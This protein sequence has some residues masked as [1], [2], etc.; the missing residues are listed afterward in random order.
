M[1]SSTVPAV[2]TVQRRKFPVKTN[3]T[4][5]F[6]TLKKHIPEIMKLVSENDVTVVSAATGSG[7]STLIPGALALMY[8]KKRVYVAVPTITAAI[9]LCKFASELY[10]NVEFGYGANGISK[11]RDTTQ[12]IYCTTGRIKQNILHNRFD[13]I[14][15]YLMIDEAHGVDVT[16]STLLHLCQNALRNREQW[17]CPNLKL[18]ISSATIDIDSWNDIFDSI[19]KFELADRS[20]P[21]DI[22]YNIR[23]YRIDEKKELTQDT[24]SLV[25]DIHC[26]GIL[27]KTFDKSAILVF[28]DS[29]ES[30][31]EIIETLYRHPKMQDCAILPAYSKLSRDELDE[32][33]K[34]IQVLNKEYEKDGYQVR[35]KIVVATNIAE[36]AITIPDVCIVVDMMR[37]RILR[38]GINNNNCLETAFTSQSESNQRSGRAGR[39]APGICFR[40]CNEM[41]FIA[42][43]RHS[44]PE[45]MRIVL[46]DQVL[47]LLAFDYDAQNILEMSESKY[48]ITLESLLERNL[49]TCSELGSKYVVTELGNFVTK[50]PTGIDMGIMLN[51]FKHNPLQ[52]YIAMIIVS[53]IDAGSNGN[54]F[55][56][57]RRNRNQTQEEHNQFLREYKEQ[58]SRFKGECDL[59]QVIKIFYAM[60]HE[61]HLVMKGRKQYQDMLKNRLQQTDTI[62]QY[63]MSEIPK[64]RTSYKSYVDWSYDNS[65]NN[66]VRKKVVSGFYNLEK[67]AKSLKIDYAIGT[68]EESL[69]M[70]PKIRKGIA[71]AL[72]FAIYENKKRSF[73]NVMSNEYGFRIDNKSSGY[74]TDIYCCGDKV[75][76]LI[77]MEIKNIDQRTR[78]PTFNK[79]ISMT[80]P[81]DDYESESDSVS[82]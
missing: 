13:R 18:V 46:Y 68:L 77:R 12:V 32:I 20:F 48:S 57:P 14:Q 5:N 42:L 75:V 71:K 69:E 50:W 25:L 64:E 33:F 72:P 3:D 81:L 67:I 24:V 63:I 8:L 28:T 37:C 82:E 1:N 15:D 35:R 70:M 78:M 55:Y 74:N 58:F 30:V 61:T 53:F 10:P 29:V 59:E 7:K 47:E 19:G 80:F 60:E 38:A 21:I 52:M 4:Q 27:H 56:V 76:G 34:P 43:P 45:H 79:F 54:I 11:F 41:D 65:I 51:G 49:I 9:T 73:T 23:S 40:M 36:S 39:T 44:V 2:P 16:T 6:L 22:K 62:F 31:E 17:N 26:G 66:K